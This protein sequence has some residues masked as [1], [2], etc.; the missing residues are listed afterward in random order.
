MSTTWIFQMRTL[1]STT[2]CLWI[3]AKP[4]SWTRERSQTWRRKS[5]KEMNAF[6]SLWKRLIKLKNACRLCNSITMW[7]P[8]RDQ[9]Q[10]KLTKMPIIKIIKRSKIRVRNLL[11]HTRDRIYKHIIF[12]IKYQIAKPIATRTRIETIRKHIPFFLQ[13][14]IKRMTIK[15][16]TWTFRRSKSIRSNSHRIHNWFTNHYPRI[17]V[18]YLQIIKSMSKSKLIQLCIQS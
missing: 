4:T 10:I 18:L 15:V 12:R 2:R 3:W 1:N 6:L 11:R 17:H 16:L 14:K 8:M 9:R 7:A 13:M 5:M